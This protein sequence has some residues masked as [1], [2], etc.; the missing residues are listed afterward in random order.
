LFND[1]QVANIQVEKEKQLLNQNT[2]C[3]PNQFIYV[4]LLAQYEYHR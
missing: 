1:L 2:H 4:G 3:A